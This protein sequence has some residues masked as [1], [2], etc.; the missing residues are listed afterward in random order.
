MTNKKMELCAPSHLHDV[1]SLSWGWFL[2]AWRLM[3]SRTKNM[4]MTIPTV[5]SHSRQQCCTVHH[6]GTPLRN[7][8]NNGGPT[9]KSAP[10]MLLTRKMKNAICIGETRPLFLLNQGRMR[11]KDAPMVRI[12]IAST[13]PEKRNSVLLAGPLGALTHRLIPQ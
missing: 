9:G 12:R 11:S 5:I 2:L 3:E 10:P 6:N 13:E 4:R 8:K 7:P 1:K